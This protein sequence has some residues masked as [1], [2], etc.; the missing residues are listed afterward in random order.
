[1][2]P[3]PLNDVFL[4]RTSSAGEEDLLTATAGGAR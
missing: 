2:P 1:L 4:H 3:A